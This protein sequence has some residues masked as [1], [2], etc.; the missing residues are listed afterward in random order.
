MKGKKV[1][2]V[3]TV[4]DDILL[5]ETMLCICIHNIATAESLNS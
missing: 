4:K 5:M 3:K 2:I 1:F